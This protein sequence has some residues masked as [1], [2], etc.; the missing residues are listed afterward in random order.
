VGGRRW[1]NTWTSASTIP[2]FPGAGYLQVSHDGGATWK[3]HVFPDT[4]TDGYYL[5][6]LLAT[7]DGH[8]WS[9]TGAKL[10]LAEGANIEA[11]VRADGVLVVQLTQAPGLTTTGYQSTDGGRT[12]HP[13]TT[14]PS[15]ANLPVA[16]AGGYACS[17][18][19]VIDKNGS[20]GPDDLWLS[21]DGKSWTRVARPNV[22]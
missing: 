19:Q 6:P 1:P 9:A 4:V 16:V 18:F 8:T 3:R 21:P 7:Y 17:G 15:N 20:T 13:D 2:I 10:P 14:H 11:M 5:P 12:L 22:P